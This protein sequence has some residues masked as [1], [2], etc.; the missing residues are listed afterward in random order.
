MPSST[1]FIALAEQHFIG[2]G[3]ELAAVLVTPS[4][5]CSGGNAHNKAEGGLTFAL[6]AKNL[7]SPFSSF[8]SGP[9]PARPG[10]GHPGGRFV[11]HGRLQQRQQ[12]DFLS[13]VGDLPI[14]GRSDRRRDVPETGLGPPTASR[15]VFRTY[16]EA[17]GTSPSGDMALAQRSRCAGRIFK[18][19]VQAS[20]R[21]G[22]RGKRRL[23]LGLENRLLQRPRKA[24][25]AAS[26][27]PQ[28][29]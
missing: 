15:Q 1:F 6:S 27:R 9:A 21:D 19:T 3:T 25:S 11:L 28:P 17:C 7:R 2:S 22:F 16:G 5:W 29:H 4:P 23:G 20:M 26:A 13:T 18:Q 14:A 8:T 12:V 10:A 24:C